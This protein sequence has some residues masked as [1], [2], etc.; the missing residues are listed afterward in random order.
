VSKSP[1]KDIPVFQTGGVAE[2]KQTNSLA[3][4]RAQSFISQV[5]IFSVFASPTKIVQTHDNA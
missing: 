4:K 3:R 2:P 5:F 1:K